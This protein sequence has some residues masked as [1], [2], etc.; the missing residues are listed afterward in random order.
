MTNKRIALI[1]TIVLLAVVIGWHLTLLSA[2]ASPR[3]A[4]RILQDSAPPSDPATPTWEYKVLVFASFAASR[5]SLGYF[6]PT[7]NAPPNLEDEI[8]KLAEQGFVVDSFQLNSG[9]G[10]GSYGF[11]GTPDIAALLKRAKK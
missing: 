6:G 4:A 1:S 9:Y 5:R 11:S 10:A 2:H 8:N 3:L 7:G